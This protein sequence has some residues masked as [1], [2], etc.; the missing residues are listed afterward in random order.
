MDLAVSETRLGDLR[1]FTGIVRDISERRQGERALAESQERLLGIIGSATD[2]IITVDESQQVTLF[3]AAAERMFQCPA[4][5]AIGKHLDQFIPHRFRAAHADHIS[6]FRNTGGTARAM[7][8]QRALAALRSDG[9]EFPVEAT[10][11]QITVA[12]QRLFTAIVRDI[13]ER[14]RAEESLARQAEELA[15]S[16]VEL[17][18][19]DYVASNDLL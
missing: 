5:R 6:L 10:I 8:A 3:N 12:G 16:N 1:V 2:A 13:S 15:R 14:Q 9:V 18:R 11:S 17:D 7:G 4:D 19:F